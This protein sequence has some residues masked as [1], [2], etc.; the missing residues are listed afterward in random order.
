MLNRPHLHHLHGDSL[1]V[2]PEGETV[3]GPLRNEQGILYA[4]VDNR[5]TA[6]AKRALD[7]VGSSLMRV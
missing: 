6:I 5:R 2:A 7:I 1:V 4:D 3:A